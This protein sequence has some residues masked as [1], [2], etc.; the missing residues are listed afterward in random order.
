MIAKIN[1]QKTVRK[2]LLAA[3]DVRCS[4]WQQATI[5]QR[6]GFVWGSSARRISKPISWIAVADQFVFAY[7]SK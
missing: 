1:K 6:N 7:L 5:E 4:C 3:Y 2:L